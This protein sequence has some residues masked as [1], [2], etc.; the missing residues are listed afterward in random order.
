MIAFFAD[1]ERN[2]ETIAGRRKR[3]GGKRSVSTG[4]ILESIEV[5]NKFAMFVEAAGRKTGVEKA[6][7]GV[8][9][10]GARGVTQDEK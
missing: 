4:R 3:A 6:A 2:E 1:R 8:C 9:R 5:E 10:R 7:G